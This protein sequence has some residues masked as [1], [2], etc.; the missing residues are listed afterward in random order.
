MQE[1][2]PPLFDEPPAI[3][4]PPVENFPTDPTQPPGPGFEWRGAPGSTPGSPNGNWYNPNTGESL[5][6]DMS[7]PEPIGPHYDYRAPSGDWYRWFPNGNMAPK[8]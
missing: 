8:A 6:P 4:R 7:H 5:R 3:V 2:L 1:L